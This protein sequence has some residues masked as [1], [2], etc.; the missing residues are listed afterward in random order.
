MQKSLTYGPKGA[1]PS[2]RGEWVRKGVMFPDK[3]G[4]VY[5]FPSPCGEWVRKEL[6]FGTLTHPGFQGS[7]STQSKT[8]SPYSPNNLCLG[9]FGSSR[10]TLGAVS[11]H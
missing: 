11:T 7:K 10:L 2:P 9:N 5:L 3:T 4:N 6:L 1:L 8:T